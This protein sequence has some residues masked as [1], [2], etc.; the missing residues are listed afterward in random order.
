MHALT[1][2]IPER[3]SIK[4]CLS[5]KDAATLFEKLFTRFICNIVSKESM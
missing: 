5:S 3:I 4:K 1:G 2:W